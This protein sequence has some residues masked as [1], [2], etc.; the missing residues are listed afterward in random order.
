MNE[1]QKACLQLA[2]ILCLVQTW[3]FAPSKHLNTVLVGATPPLVTS[4]TCK[5]VG[6][7][8]PAKLIANNSVF[9][10]ARLPLEEQA[11]IVTSP[12][13]WLLVLAPSEEEGSKVGV[14]VPPQAEVRAPSC[15]DMRQRV[16][17]NSTASPQP[18]GVAPSSL[19]LPCLGCA[20]HAGARGR[21]WNSC[22][23]AGCPARHRRGHLGHTPTES[24]QCGLGL[25][26][27]KYRQ[28]L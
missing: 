25:A 26:N 27:L 24:F 9:K 21:L 6:K 19:P 12:S 18:W 2:S 5:K 10:V 3:G 7:A 13:S 22:T 14:Q 4:S 11:S 8:S 1:V 23:L 17:G 28:L 20:E 16:W 15:W